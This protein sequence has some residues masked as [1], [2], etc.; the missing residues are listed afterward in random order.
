TS[1]NPNTPSSTANYEKAWGEL[2]NTGVYSA[3]DIIMV[4]GNG[5]WRASNEQIETAFKNHYVPL[6]EKARAS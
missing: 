3:N 2:A 4:S 6:L 1:A 5:P